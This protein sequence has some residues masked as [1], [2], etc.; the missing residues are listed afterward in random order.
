MM[1][2]FVVLSIILLIML[3]VLNYM[4]D[5]YKIMSLFF[6]TTPFLMR[7][8]VMFNSH[9]E[10]KQKLN[11]TWFEMLNGFIYKHRKE[12]PNVY[13]SVF[14]EKCPVDARDDSKCLEKLKEMII[15]SFI[16]LSDGCHHGRNDDIV[17][18]P[19]RYTLLSLFFE[20]LQ[21]NEIM[22]PLTIVVI[23]RSS[24]SL[25]R[26]FIVSFKFIKSQFTF[27]FKWKFRCICMVSI[28]L[29]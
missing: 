25:F 27:N 3:F 7:C 21:I 14:S 4:S 5:N 24:I 1:E 29:F 6:I 2:S 8:M 18:L 28:F 20:D 9:Y 19:I 16:D 12:I 26:C 23:W 15:F 13:C 11:D 22:K 10:D 17:V